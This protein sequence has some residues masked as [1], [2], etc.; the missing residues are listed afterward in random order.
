MV[1]EGLSG[2]IEFSAGVAVIRHI[3]GETPKPPEFNLMYIG[4]LN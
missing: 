4:I 3:L 2:L 1:D